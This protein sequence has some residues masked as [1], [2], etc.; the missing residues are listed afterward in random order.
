MPRVIWAVDAR[1]DL[2]RIAD[3][4]ALDNPMAA[5]R[6]I[7]TITSR[8]HLLA[9]HPQIGRAIGGGQ[10]KLN[11]GRYPYNLI[12]RIA[13]NEVEILRIRHMAEDWL[14]R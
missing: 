13:G 4:I 1:D 7:D 2:E 5:A 11:A 6:V 8:D 10:R 3:Y 14:P 9:E 12:Y